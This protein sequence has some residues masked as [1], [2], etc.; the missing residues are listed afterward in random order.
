MRGAPSTDDGGVL[1]VRTSRS[2]T[3]RTYDRLSRYYDRTE[4]FFET[5]ARRRA[6][7][8][9]NAAAGEA[10]LEVGC[11]TGR[12]LRELRDAVGERGVVCGVDL[13]PAML[14]VTRAQV[15][16]EA[17]ALVVGDATALPLQASRFD[18]VFMSFV[19]ELI[20]T[21]E[22]PLVLAEVHRVL[23][24]GGRLVVLSLSRVR[25]NLM[26][27]LWELGHRAF[28]RL[29]DCR[30]IYVARSLAERFHIARADRILIWGLP[31]EI[32]LA[33]AE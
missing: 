28:P 21:E 16:G 19:L 23:K 27:K 1:P 20:P 32:V 13:S 25:P 11:G 15:P 12:A 10:V 30:P 9:A 22:I 24:P 8:T 18:L 29:L 4:G 3:Q 7:A 31:A 26:T 6:L 2:E 14:R 17:S 33:H 5:A